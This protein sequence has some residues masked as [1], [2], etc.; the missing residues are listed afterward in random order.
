MI[1]W[2]ALDPLHGP[3]KSDYGTKIAGFVSVMLQNFIQNFSLIP[4]LLYNIWTRFL[5]FHDS[6]MGYI[7][8]TLYIIPYI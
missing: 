6:N 8:N 5:R 7:T 3:N 2:G 4:P 1:N